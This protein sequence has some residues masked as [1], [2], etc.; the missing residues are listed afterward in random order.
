MKQPTSFPEILE[1][2]RTL[3]QAIADLREFLE[4]P[5]PESGQ[6]ERES[7]ASTL[8]RKLTLLHG[9]TLRHFR[10]EERGGGI[11]EDLETHH[12]RA[13]AAVAGLRRDHDRILAE[14]R[15]LLP[16]VLIYGEGKDPV[17][18]HLRQWTLS[19]LEDFSEHEKEETDLFQRMHYQDV[20]GG[21]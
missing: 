1:E 10:Q 2:H 5:R 14:V 9:R 6:E 18:P 12:P 4:Q 13:A 17:N 21:E 15:A 19:V 16:A 11:F 3:R 20:E 7:W 8:A